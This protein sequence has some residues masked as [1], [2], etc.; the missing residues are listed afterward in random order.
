MPPRAKLIALLGLILVPTVTYYGPVLPEIAGAVLAM[1]LVWA[2]PGSPLRDLGLRPP[3][4]VWRALGTGIAVG[5]ALFLANRLLLT[6]LLEYVIGERRNLSSF[7]YLRGNMRALFALLPLIWVTAGVCE[8]IVY[9]AYLITRTE[10]LLGNWR[11]AGFLSCLLSAAIFGLAHWYQGAVGMLITGMLGLVLGIVFLL[12]DR[13]L[14]TNIA[15][16]LVADTVSSSFISLNWDRP[17][18]VFGR[19]LF[20]L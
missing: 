15:A 14:W 11:F 20:G 8:E 9:R 10:K 12:Q 13:N 19:A 2:E 18:D 6:P 7:D 4:K 17:L 3:P 5:I 1:V 16:H